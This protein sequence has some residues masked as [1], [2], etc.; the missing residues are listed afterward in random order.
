[1]AG[2]KRCIYRVYGTHKYCSW[3][4]N[5]HSQISIRLRALV[6]FFNGLCVVV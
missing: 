6:D 3:L 2:M 5:A 4:F 1:M